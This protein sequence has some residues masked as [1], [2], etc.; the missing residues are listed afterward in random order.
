MT[1]ADL[2]KRAALTV[3]LGH[4]IAHTAEGR[5][6]RTLREALTAAATAIETGDAHPWI[7]TEEGDILSPRWIE[8]NTGARRVQ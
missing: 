2:D 6:Y 1:R 3:W 5:E 7:I 4:S 8:E